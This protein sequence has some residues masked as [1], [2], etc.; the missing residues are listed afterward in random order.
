M[1]IAITLAN[2]SNAVRSQATAKKQYDT[3]KSQLA[4]LAANK[5]EAVANE[6]YNKADDFKKK[7]NSLASK[8]PA[9]LLALQEANRAVQA[10]EQ[11]Q[12]SAKTDPVAKLMQKLGISVQEML[13]RPDFKEVVDL[14]V[15]LAT[16]ENPN[17]Q[18]SVAH[19]QR[20]RDIEEQC[21]NLVNA[22]W[23]IKRVVATYPDHEN[24]IRQ[25]IS[26]KQW[27]L[28]NPN[29]PNE[30]IQVGVRGYRILP[31]W[32]TDILSNHPE[33]IVFQAK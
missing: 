6:E 32:A 21:R 1:A 19:R 13:E 2:Y 27:I 5:A 16:S 12:Q 4:A 8:K 23:T 18:I 22:G 10:I 28:A 20:F 26:A 30:Q 24:S 29:N 9:L 25:F 7:E 15:K 17:Q 31:Q 11:L 14:M 33:P 3:N